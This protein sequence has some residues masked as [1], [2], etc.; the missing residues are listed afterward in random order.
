M[1]DKEMW[2]LCESAHRQYQT[3]VLQQKT[4]YPRFVNDFLSYNLFVS[5]FN[6]ERWRVHALNLVRMHD[7]FKHRPDLVHHFF[8]KKDYTEEDHARLMELFTKGEPLAEALSHSSRRNFLCILNRAQLELMTEY[9]NRQ[10]FFAKQL[11]SHEVYSLFACE[12]QAP[13][14]LRNNGEF[15]FFLFCLQTADV[16]QGRWQKILAD[17]GNILSSSSGKVWTAYCISSSLNSYRKQI[18]DMDKFTPFAKQIKA[19]EKKS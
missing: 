18:G 6:L 4:C 15:A 13:L 8:G 2:A 10:G 19:L 1:T 9:V 14:K 17:T 7:L 16:V 12:N 5:S 11:T 3:D